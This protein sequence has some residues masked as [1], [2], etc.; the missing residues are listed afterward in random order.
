MWYHLKVCGSGVYNKAELS[1]HGEQASKQ[2]LSIASASASASRFLAFLVP[3]LTSL[4][5]E[6][7]CGS[8]NQINLFLTN[9]HFG[10]GVPLQQK[11]S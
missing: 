1:G 5:N 11:K 8:R 2:Q 4:D 3:V 9:L 6:Q 7:Q 10:Q